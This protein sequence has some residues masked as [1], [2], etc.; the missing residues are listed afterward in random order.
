MDG[1]T[2]AWVGLG[3]TAGVQIAAA[4][5]MFGTL[6]GKLT[7]LYN[8]FQRHEKLSANKAHGSTSE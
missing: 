6:N 4:G 7:E 2:V 5:W 3:L 1:T 8:R